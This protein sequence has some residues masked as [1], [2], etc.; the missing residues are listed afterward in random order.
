MG[1]IGYALLGCFEQGICLEKFKLCVCSV[2]TSY[3]SNLC[4]Y[5]TAVSLEYR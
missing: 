2:P 4:M 3:R 1:Q 5:K